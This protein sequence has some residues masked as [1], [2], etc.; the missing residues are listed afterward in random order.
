MKIRLFVLVFYL[1]IS[2]ICIIPGYILTLVLS[3]LSQ[4]YFAA[5]GSR[6]GT[7]ATP[8]S[9]TTTISSRSRPTTETLGP[10]T[11]RCLSEAYSEGGANGAV[12]P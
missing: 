4:K 5:T 3:M 1:D 10:S 2:V 6:T 8:A 12:L 7:S 11:R 9:T